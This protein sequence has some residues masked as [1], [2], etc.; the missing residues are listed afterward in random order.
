VG[1]DPESRARFNLAA[2]SILV[3]E[4]TPLGM[5][6]VAQILSGF[7]GRHLYRCSTVGEAKQVLGQSEVHLV[8]AD[9]ISQSGE[10][11]ELVE[12]LRKEAPEPNRYVPVLLTAAHTRA[13]DVRRSRDCGSHYIVAKPIAPIV[14]LERIIWVSREGRGFLMSDGYVGPDRRV[15][16][17]GPAVG[18]KGRRRDDPSQPAKVEGL[19]ADVAPQDTAAVKP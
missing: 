16:D 4:P 3:L 17:T 8:I 2:A 14:M 6:I 18:R 15:K 9:S 11:Y 10:G 7:G 19:A 1:L 12:W 5:S 13:R